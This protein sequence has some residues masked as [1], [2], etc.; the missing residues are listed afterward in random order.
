MLYGTEHDTPRSCILYTNNINAQPLTEFCSRDLCAIRL[1]TQEDHNIPEVILASAYMPEEEEVPPLEL[2][3]LVSYCESGGMQLVVAA[4]SNA[5]HPLWGMKT[6]NNR[7]KK[8]FEYLFTTHLTLLNTGTTPTFIN[9]R[10]STIIDLTLASEEAAGL[11]QDWHVSSEASCSDHRW[12]RFD[13]QAK[14]NNTPPK[15]NPRNT[16]KGKYSRLVYSKLKDACTPCRLEDTAGIE[17]HVAV[18]TTTMIDS[19][20]ATCPLATPKL[21][22]KG[23]Q[24]WW[25]PELERL[26][27]K[28]RK[29][30]NR[31]MNTSADQDWENYKEAKSRYKKRIRFRSSASWKK[32]CSS[33]ENCEQANRVRKVLSKQHTAGI[34]S[35]RKPDNTYTTSPAETQRTLLETHFPGCK[36]I[37]VT[38]WQ[39]ATHTPTETCWHTAYE[40]VSADKVQWA[41]QT[42]NPF[43]A[44]GPDGIFPALIQWGGTEV[45][46]I[47]T[48][49]M[50]AC[51]A[52]RYV[53]KGWREVEVIFIPK[54]GKSDYTDAKSFRPISLTSFLLKTLERLCDR[55]LRDTVLKNIPLHRHQHAY[56]SG[57][58][59]ESALHM[60]V[61]R[62]EE[63]IEEKGICLGTFID[64]EGAFDKTN[65]SSIDNALT[66]HGADP[67]LKGWI[68]NMLCKR[69][70]RY[71]GEP[72]AALVA[73]GCPQGG[74]LSPLLW[75]LV[76]NDLI[77]ILNS[78]YYYTIGYA[79]DLTILVKGKEASTVCQLTQSALRIVERWCRKYDLSVNPNKTE[80]VMFTKKRT[81]GA[82]LPPK[83]FNT[84]L[85]FATQV[86]YLGLILDSKLNW[87][88]HLD[89]KIDKAA[90]TFWQCRRMV[91]K[92]WGLSPKITLWLYK[93]VIRPMLCYGALVWWPRTRLSTGKLKL[94]SFQR[95]ACAATTGCMRT[96]PSAALEAILDVPPLHLFIEQ[97][98]AISAI[99]L[100]TLGLW[101]TS[102]IAHASILEE[103]YQDLPILAA[104]N[105]RIPKQFVFDKK[106]KI[107]LYENN[108][109][110][111]LTSNELRIFT[112]G[113]KTKSGT[114]SGIFSEDFNMHISVPL[115]S[116]NTVFQAECMGI[117]VATH[118]IAARQVRDHSIRILSDSMA[119]LQ[120]L[121]SNCINSGL[122]YNCY[123]ALMQVCTDNNVILQWIKG[124]SE[125]RG[126]DAAD[127]LAR[128]GSEVKAIGPEPIIPIPFRQVR[129]LL[130]AR[131]AK[132]HESEW[133]DQV[134]CRQAKMALPTINSRLSKRLL[135]L[136]RPQLRQVTSVI[137]GHGLFNKHLFTIGVTD[138]PLCRACME[139]EETAA[140]VVLECS[141]VANYRAKHLGLTGCF[142]EVVG[143]TKGLLDFLEELGWLE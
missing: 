98:A 39:D 20:H 78:Q 142:P 125:S 131:T 143:N 52:H 59:T 84:E 97:E 82:Y 94:Q 57:K 26:R 14:A 124:H 130:T 109:C 25:G 19:Y 4:D 123:Q 45:I 136:R 65:F 36:L 12:I 72:Q 134:E 33:I 6:S 35:I 85:K 96:A 66:K 61:S 99:R 53:P 49:I 31:A 133:N 22:H 44:P 107:Q 40:V 127:E 63:A 122:V 135:S 68:N 17:N 118:A 91:G 15:R 37:E 64:I 1:Q 90:I 113:S 46:E 2:A 74:V 141:G 7:G 106:Y 112:D 71:A 80:I 24:P 54:P 100:K 128:R 29:L 73:K 48:S 30:L 115:G 28:V 13:L 27:G 140:H 23:G 86:K 8:L 70:V 34:G 138:S 93:T 87:S 11:V 111:G 60:V 114:G 139:E 81:F 77:T 119:V 75:N 101:K 132:A 105:D 83:L 5:H 38:D 18:I 129:T 103:V 104:V 10:S 116:H 89:T 121:D 88:A 56:S 32:F 117:L 120:A 92:K 126:N 16:D 41:I 43:K 137:T 42:F 21:L 51:L 47:L 50:R 110:E 67:V 95:L 58:S 55:E 9:K 3:R 62:I 76:I 79:D 69:I 108:L 102:R